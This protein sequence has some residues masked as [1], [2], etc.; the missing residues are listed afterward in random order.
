MKLSKVFV[1]PMVLVLLW[2]FVLFNPVV[3]FAY[4][5][6]DVKNGGS[7][8][9][10]V[11]LKGVIPPLRV[12]PIGLYPFSQ[13]C[14]KIS[15][16]DNNVLLEEFFVGTGGGL[17]DAIV[18]VQNVQKGKPFTHLKASMVSVDCMFHPAEALPAEVDVVE[19]DNTIHHEHP[20]VTVLENHRTLS[21]VNKDPIIHNMQVYQNQKGNIILNTPL[22]ISDE[23]RGGIL[24]FEADN[25]IAHMICGMHEFMQSWAYV[26]DNP[27]YTNTKKDGDFLINDIPPGTYEVVVWHPHLKP[28]THEVTISANQSSEINVEFDSSDVKRPL[29]ELQDSFRTAPKDHVPGHHH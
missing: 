3:S 5:T 23:P 25:K 29:Y 8:R 10:K 17:K 16:G 6:I 20:L 27:Y 24:D 22:P 14:K 11:T 12:F 9:G 4:E 28:I 21:V 18:T 7:I 26:I 13:F 1:G 15:D 2:V 19:M